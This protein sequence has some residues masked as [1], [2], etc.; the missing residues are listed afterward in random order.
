VY[1]LR[2]SDFLVFGFCAITKWKE[3]QTHLECVYSL[4]ELKNSHF[5]FT[6][7]EIVLIGFQRKRE[8]KKPNSSVH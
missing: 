7:K 5:T 8:K 2:N 6:E 3:N 4:Y 1:L